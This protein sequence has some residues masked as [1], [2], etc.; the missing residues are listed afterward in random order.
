MNQPLNAAIQTSL[1]H[2]FSS[3]PLAILQSRTAIAWQ[4]EPKSVLR[5]GFG[6]FSDI[7]PR[8]VVD[9]AGVNPPY[10]K[11]L[12]RANFLV[13]LSKR[14]LPVVFLPWP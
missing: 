4:F 10:V 6:V 9:V 12:L 7:L 8:S 2:V 5:A 1:G 11:T 13:L 3:T 14:I